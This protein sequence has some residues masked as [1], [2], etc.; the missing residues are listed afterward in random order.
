MKR[1]S[2]N[3]KDKKVIRDNGIKD[4]INIADLKQKIEKVDEFRFL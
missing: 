3:L 4:S 1:I 2:K